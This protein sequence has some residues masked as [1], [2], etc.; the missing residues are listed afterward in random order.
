[1]ASATCTKCAR[2]TW[3]LPRFCASC[4]ASLQGWKDHETR[5]ARTATNMQALAL[6]IILRTWCCAPWK[7]HALE[8][9]G[10]T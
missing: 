1:M 3:R 4:Y 6:A 8:L 9:L 10:S 7:V 5:I 2:M